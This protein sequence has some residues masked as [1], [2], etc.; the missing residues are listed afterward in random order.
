MNTTLYQRIESLECYLHV[1]YP[2]LNV[3]ILPCNNG[4]RWK[5]YNQYID[6]HIEQ[7]I[8]AYLGEYLS[9][10]YWESS[11]QYVYIK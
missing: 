3:E 1:K 6:E 2:L 7:D 11:Y 10:F 5:Q 9:E 8:S 4:I